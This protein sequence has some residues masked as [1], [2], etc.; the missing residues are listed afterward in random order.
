MKM[1]S[2]ARLLDGKIFTAYARPWSPPQKSAIKSKGLSEEEKASVLACHAQNMSS[3]AITKLLNIGR[4]QVRTVVGKFKAG[5]PLSRRKGSGRPRK[6]CSE[7]DRK[8]VLDIKRNPRMTARDILKENSDLKV[9]EGTI[10]MRIK[11]TGEFGNYFTINKPVITEKNRLARVR[12][13][14]EHK[15]WTSE[16]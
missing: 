7:Q 6:T 2:N 11:E 13:G 16:Q 10:I 1:K 9:S 4:W 3:T 5:E 12:W 15:D 14:K 8:I